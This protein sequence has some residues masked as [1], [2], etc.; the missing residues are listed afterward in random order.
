MKFL[1]LL[2]ATA[3]AWPEN[4]HRQ[5]IEES[6]QLCHQLQ[7][8]GKYLGASPLEPGSDSI[9]VR[10]RDGAAQVTD[11]PFAETKEVLGGYFLIQASNMQEAIEVAK[12]IPGIRRGVAEIRQIMEIQGLP[13]D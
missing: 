11:G 9:L 12:R 10:V 4:E 3:D 5:A 1:I 13:N 8:E 7:A 2:H 6:V